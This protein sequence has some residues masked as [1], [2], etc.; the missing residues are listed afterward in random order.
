MRHELRASRSRRR[1]GIMCAGALVALATGCQAFGSDNAT[2]LPTSVSCSKSSMGPQDPNAAA[3]VGDDLKTA[4]QH[5][6][7]EGK[8]VSVAG[9][10]GMCASPVDLNING[11]RVDVY[12][13]HGKVVW[14]RIG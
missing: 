4:Q 10:D 5:A 9:Q 7:G 3:F 14:S 12:L 6:A 8:R 11:T 13:E 2:A 1:I